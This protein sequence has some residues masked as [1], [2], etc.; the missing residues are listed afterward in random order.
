[1]LQSILLAAAVFLASV[2]LHLAALRWCSNGMA[3]IRLTPWTRSMAVSVVL[4][5]AHLAEIGLYAVVYAAAEHWFDLGT[6]SGEPVTTGVDYFYFSAITYTSLGI[7]DIFPTE[8]LRF[9]TGVEALGGLLLIAWS[10]S[11]LF[12]LMSRLWKWHPFADHDK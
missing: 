11:F 3:A 12:A 2:G 7:G 10:A 9:L 5:A 8:H 6:F 4:F 1:M